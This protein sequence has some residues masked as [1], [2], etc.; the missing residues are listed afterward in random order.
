MAKLCDS[1]GFLVTLC[2][3]ICRTL[4]KG[5]EAADKGKVSGV[6]QLPLARSTSAPAEA[7]EDSR[8]EAPSSRA[9]E[10]DVPPPLQTSGPHNYQTPWSHA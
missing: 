1:T 3:G 2:N 9:T 4:G 6:P 5:K 7:P 8:T 10:G